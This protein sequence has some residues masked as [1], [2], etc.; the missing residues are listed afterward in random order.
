[1]TWPNLRF[2]CTFELTKALF[3]NLT[4]YSL[5]YLSQYLNLK[6]NEQFFN[7]NFAHSARYDAQFTYQLYCNIQSI[8]IKETP[9]SQPNPFGTS[10][11]DI[12]FQ[13]H[14]DLKVIHQEQFE[15]LK[16]ILDEIK[17]DQN[18]QSKC[19]VVSGEAGNRFNYTHSSTIAQILALKAH[20]QDLTLFTAEELQIILEQNSIRRVLN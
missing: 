6:V 20:T 14:I 12:P 4:S 2:S 7:R 5:E 15:Y 18:H 17:L 13:N 9:P 19:V 10:R 1:M 11:V 8:L 16:S 3:K